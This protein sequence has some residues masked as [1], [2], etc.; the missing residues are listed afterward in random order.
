M[1]KIHAGTHL[2]AQAG[3]AMQEILGSTDKV[4]GI[5]N[6]IAS[7]SREQSAGIIQVNEAITLMDTVTQQNAALVE[8]AAAAAGSLSLQTHTL[9]KALSV[10]KLE[11][12]AEHTPVQVNVAKSRHPTALSQRTPTSRALLT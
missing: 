5:M 4:S 12:G 9:V 3:N 1:E 10:F 11:H 7:A 2:T 8:E 6:E